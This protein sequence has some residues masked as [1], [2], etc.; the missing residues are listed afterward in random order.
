MAL[1]V[2]G[3]ANAADAV[4]ILSM[5]LVLPAAEDDLKLTATAKGALSSCVF[6]GML[7]GGLTWGTMGDTI[8]ESCC[9]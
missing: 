4:E 6:L 7:I 5:G 2:C 9:E 1:A 8:G 3:L